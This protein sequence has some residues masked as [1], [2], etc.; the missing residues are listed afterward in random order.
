M[1]DKA[2]FG[3]SGSEGAPAAMFPGSNSDAPTPDDPQSV[4]ADER[5]LIAQELHDSAF[6]ILALLQ[7]NFGRLRRLRPG[8]FEALI[9]ESEELVR[10]IAHQ[11]RAVCETDEPRPEL[12]THP[13]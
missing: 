12:P 2:R 5:R 9:S 8:E 3:P 13:R 1:G 7:L 6:Q 10:Q 4:R 11:L